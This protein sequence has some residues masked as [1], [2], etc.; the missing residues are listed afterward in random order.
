MALKL[1]GCSPVRM[2]EKRSRLNHDA[3]IR[4]V[5]RG[6]RYADIAAR[7]KCSP[8]TVTRIVQERAPAL[9]RSPR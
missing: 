5:V 4:E 8:G 9:R 6:D 1:Y 3:I 2:N 7:H